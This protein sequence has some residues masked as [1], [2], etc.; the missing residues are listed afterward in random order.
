MYPDGVMTLVHG[1]A[2]VPD[3]SSVGDDRVVAVFL[4]ASGEIHEASGLQYTIEHVAY[5]SGAVTA[6]WQGAA[7]SACAAMPK[8]PCLA[9]GAD[10]A[11][12]NVTGPG[13][14]AV[15][16]GGTV[17]AKLTVTGGAAARKLTLLLRR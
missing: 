3:A 15:S 13:A 14:L 9:A 2:A 8:A 11:T 4:G 17:A 12:A 1:S 6:T 10:G 5:G 7:L 16:L